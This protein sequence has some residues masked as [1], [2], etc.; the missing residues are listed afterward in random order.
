MI[1]QLRRGY[2]PPDSGSGRDRHALF[3][4]ISVGIPPAPAQKSI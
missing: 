1:D 4:C 3:Q 2:A